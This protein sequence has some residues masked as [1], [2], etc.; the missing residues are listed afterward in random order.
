MEHRLKNVGFFFCVCVLLRIELRALCVPIKYSTTEQHHQRKEM[1]LDAVMT[2]A[3]I[4]SID[5]MAEPDSQAE[6]CWS[7]CVVS[8]R[9]RTSNLRLHIFN[10]SSCVLKFLCAL[11]IVTLDPSQVSVTPGCLDMFFEG[12]H[13]F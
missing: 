5:R 4:H 3:H 9:S 2:L 1:I 12:V 13:E 7:A 6:G 11:C 10:F 8:P